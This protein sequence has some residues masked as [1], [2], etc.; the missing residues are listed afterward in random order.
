MGTSG[1]VGTL[2]WADETAG[3]LRD[4]DVR[5]LQRQATVIRGS[6]TRVAKRDGPAKLHSVS[7]EDLQIPDS[8]SCQSILAFIRAV[9]PQ[10]MLQH[11]L[12]TFMW[13]KLLAKKDD[14]GFDA[15]VL[16]AASLFH[17][18]GLVQRYSSESN[19]PENSDIAC[20]SISGARVGAQQLQEMGWADSRIDTVR[21]AIVLHLNLLVAP[22]EGVEAHLLSAGSAFDSIGARQKEIERRVI[23]QVIEL[24]PI[25]DMKTQMVSQCAAQADANPKSRIAFLVNRGFNKWVENSALARQ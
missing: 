11:C 5:E 1:S 21:S 4:V 6:A 18:L 23:A 17:D 16:F 9:C 24:H 8:V 2:A 14:V 3:R 13:A 10:W 7:A 19:S 25:L 15:E 20:Y 12:R 22:E